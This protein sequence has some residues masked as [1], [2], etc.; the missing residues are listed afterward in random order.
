MSSVPA[1][2]AAALALCVA[3]ALSVSRH[4]FRA[5]WRDLAARYATSD[6]P[7]TP[8]NRFRNV[9]CEAHVAG[10]AAGGPGFT[11]EASADGVTLC[12][13]FWHR[14]LPCVSIPWMT[15]ARSQLTTRPLGRA[16]AP[17]LRIETTHIA[18]WLLVDAPAADCLYRYWR[19]GR[20]HRTRGLGN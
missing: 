17:C 13:P 9:Y 14:P 1:L 15:V 6:P 4:R 18:D 11:V 2:L 16:L 8:A 10:R 19:S 20:G 5:A 12:P 7:P 3:I